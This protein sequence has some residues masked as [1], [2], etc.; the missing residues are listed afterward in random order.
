MTIAKLTS[1]KTSLAIRRAKREEMSK[2]AD[3][4][5]SSADWYAKFVDEKDMSEHTPDESWCQ[6]NFHKRDFYIGND[7]QFDVGTISMQEMNGF[8]YLGYIYLDTK[9]MGKG[10][11]HELMRF[12]KQKAKDR[13]LKG[14]VLIA[15]PEANWAVKAYTKFGFQLVSKARKEVL[16]WNNG[17]LKSYYEEGFHL[18][19]LS[20]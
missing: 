16:S 1:P 4:I 8:A 17:A 5:T 14:M 2:I 11:G 6:R 19:K 13:G 3:F 12:A 20:L 18:Y 7:G 10:Y 15:H 9:H